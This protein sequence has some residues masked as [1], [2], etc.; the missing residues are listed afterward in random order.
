MKTI[1]FIGVGNMG[2][3]LAKAACLQSAARD[4][5]IYDAD[6]E[7]MEAFAKETSG[8]TAASVG[9]WSGKAMRCSCV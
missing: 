1:G 4:V 2:G 7:K 9:G 5:V 6:K 3:A 8:R